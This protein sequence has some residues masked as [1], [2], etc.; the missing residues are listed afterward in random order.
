M[1]IH[2]ASQLIALTSQP[3]RGKDLGTLNIIE[4][5]AML[6]H[7]ESIVAVGTSEE[8]LQKYPNERRL[9]VHGKVVMPGLIDPHTHLVWAGDR[10]V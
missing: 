6:I 9:D 7:G 3:Q 8:L 1:L 4:Q 2:N 10:A 5:G